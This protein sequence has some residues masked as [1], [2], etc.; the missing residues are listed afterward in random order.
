[1]FSPD[2]PGG[3]QAFPPV[4][5][6]RWCHPIRYTSLQQSP[7]VIVPDVFWIFFFDGTRD[8]FRHETQIRHEGISYLHLAEKFYGRGKYSVH[9]AMFGKLTLENIH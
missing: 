9:G 2:V 1:M 3:G 5:P 8:E 6:C 4:S 7:K